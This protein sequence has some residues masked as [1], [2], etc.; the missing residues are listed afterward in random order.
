M[1]PLEKAA[2]AFVEEDG[3]FEGRSGNPVLE[4]ANT[5]TGK[6]G[7]TSEIAHELLSPQPQ[8]AWDH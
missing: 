4:G 2:G 8:Q 7:L 3:S 5:R 1:E 6:S